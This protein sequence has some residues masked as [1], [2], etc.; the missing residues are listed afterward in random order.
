MQALEHAQRSETGL[1]EFIENK[2]FSTLDR[3]RPR[4][5]AQRTPAGQLSFHGYTVL[6]AVVSR[7]AKLLFQLQ[8]RQE[9][10]F[11]ER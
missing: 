8:D 3:F 5:T 4:I 7:H 2:M 10:W 6:I 11:S 9:G 1:F